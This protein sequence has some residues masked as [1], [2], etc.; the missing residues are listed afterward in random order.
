MI[1]LNGKHVLRAMSIVVSL[2]IIR[3]MMGDKDQDCSW[4]FR[5]LFNQL[6]WLIAK[7]NFVV[8]RLWFAAI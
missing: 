4:N 8:L 3:G 1:W 7:K 2:I 6:T 5:L